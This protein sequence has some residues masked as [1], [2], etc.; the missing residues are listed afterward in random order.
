MF[1]ILPALIPLFSAP[2]EAARLRFP[3]EHVAATA[4]RF[5]LDCHQTGLTMMWYEPINRVEW[6][7]RAAVSNELLRPWQELV[8]VQSDDV[9]EGDENPERTRQESLERLRAMLGGE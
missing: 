4:I 1:L 7:R 5:N 8:V 2:V 3:P 9:E 6:R